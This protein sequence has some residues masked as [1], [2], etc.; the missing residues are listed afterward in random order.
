VTDSFVP[1]FRDEMITKSKR[2]FSLGA[3]AADNH[4]IALQRFFHLFH[5]GAKHV[6]MYLSL[7]R[8][9][10]SLQDYSSQSGDTDRL[11]VLPKAYCRAE[12]ADCGWWYNWRPYR[13]FKSYKHN[14]I[15]KFALQENLKE[16][17]WS[18]SP[19][20]KRRKSKKEVVEPDLFRQI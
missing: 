13:M 15:V 18:L 19:M 8:V 5:R 14:N 12:S 7:A 11:I 4:R 17:E 10:C 3:M 1:L 6:S 16:F 2:T 20:Q 9:D